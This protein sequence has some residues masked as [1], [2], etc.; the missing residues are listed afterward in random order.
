MTP[1]AIITLLLMFFSELG[2]WDQATKPTYRFSPKPIWSDEFNQ[3]GLLDSTKWTYDVGGNGWG[4]NELQY[5]TYKNPKNARIENGSLIIETHKEHFGENHYTSARLVTRG[6][7]DFR[8]GRFE[9]RAKL[10][11]GRGTWPAIWMLASKPIY[12][13][14]YLPY[15][16]EIDLMEHVGYD[17]GRV[18]TTIHTKSF[19][20]SNGTVASANRKLN[21]F[22]TAFHV[23]RVDWTP[24]KIEAFIDNELILS[25]PKVSNRWEE[26]PFDQP[27]HIL[28]NIAVGGGWGGLKGVDESIFPQR[29]EIDYVRVY[30]LKSA[31]KKK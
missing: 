8:Y 10:P 4:N 9:V 18:H 19:N 29:M 3:N 20:E 25:F 26:Y 16:G 15:N 14:N 24:D 2:V 23:Y 11:K 28:L 22:D 31:P 7:G 13:K 27:F 21:D 5:Y 1:N 30:P 12:D 17:P 6:K